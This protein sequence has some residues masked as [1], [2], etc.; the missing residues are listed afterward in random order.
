MFRDMRVGYCHGWSRATV[1]L[2]QC[3]DEMLHFVHNF[4]LHYKKNKNQICSIHLPKIWSQIIDV[5][6]VPALTAVV[7]ELL[8]VAQPASLIVQYMIPKFI[9][10]M[11]FK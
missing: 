8:L 11:A 7:E 5:L 6:A 2:C 9:E 1:L 4:E 3:F 10:R